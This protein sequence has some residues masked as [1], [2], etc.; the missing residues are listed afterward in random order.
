MTSRHAEVAAPK[1][2][3]ARQLPAHPKITIYCWSI[4]RQCQAIAGYLAASAAGQSA[5]LW[6]IRYLSGPNGA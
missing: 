6:F 5:S 2:Q 3:H 4:K 1:L